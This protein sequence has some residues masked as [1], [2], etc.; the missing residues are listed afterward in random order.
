MT[1]AL[2]AGVENVTVC[3][4]GATTWTVSERPP[5]LFRSS[6]QV[7]ESKLD[8]P[9]RASEHEDRPCSDGHVAG[10]PGREEGRAQLCPGGD[11]ARRRHGLG[12]RGRRAR[13]GEV[14]GR[15]LQVAHER[16]EVAEQAAPA[17]LV[18]HGRRDLEDG[19]QPGERHGAAAGDPPSGLQVGRERQGGGERAAGPRAGAGQRLRAAGGHGGRRPDDEGQHRADQSG[20]QD[21]GG[22]AEQA[23]TSWCVHG[24]PP[25]SG[26][27]GPGAIPPSRP[28]PGGLAPWT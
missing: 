9:E 5:G 24:R 1:G 14:R 11:R 3:C 17:V 28:R 7:R 4:T 20:D 10:A 13:L 26:R 18:G 21:P 25:G 16:L 6:S 27:P 2:G 8:V 19:G 22:Q 15:E 12:D 23:R